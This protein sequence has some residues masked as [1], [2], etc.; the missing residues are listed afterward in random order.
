MDCVFLAV[1]FLADFAGGLNVN[2][3]SQNCTMIDMGKMVHL[4]GSL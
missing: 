1:W 4:M 3:T 2:I